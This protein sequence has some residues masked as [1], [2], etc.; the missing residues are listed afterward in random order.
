MVVVEK[1]TKISALLGSKDV[2]SEQ[3]ATDS[4]SKFLLRQLKYQHLCVYNSWLFPGTIDGSGHIHIAFSNRY[5]WSL[6]WSP[7]L[8]N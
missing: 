4:E 3:N 5:H 2:Y 6:T 8:V 7:S 1:L